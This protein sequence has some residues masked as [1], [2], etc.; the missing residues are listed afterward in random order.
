MKRDDVRAIAS[1]AL[2]PATFGELVSSWVVLTKARIGTFVVLA[3][4]TGGMLAGGGTQAFTAAL[5]AALYIGLVAA[6]SGVF[7]QVIERDVDARMPRTQNRPLVTGRIRVKDAIYVAALLAVVGTV[8]LAARFN[9]LTAL[10]S[11]GTLLA[12]T[13]VYTPLKRFT[14]LNTA[15][16]A[17]PGAM[18]PLLGYLAI[19]GAPGPW[20][21]VLFALL[22]VWQFPHFLAIAWLYRDDYKAGGMIMLPTLPHSEGVAGRQALLY[23]LAMLPVALLPFLRGEAG[24]LYAAGVLL[25]SVGYAVAAAFFA[26]RETVARARAVLFVSLAFLPLLFSLVLLDPAVSRAIAS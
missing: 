19:A 4:V 18:P 11:L 7:N 10:C 6:A 17:I 20:G 22:F 24:F 23:S 9:L 2:A 21:W 12:Y 26:H 5:E 25:L 14:S 1:D 15:V 8:G 13:L 16:G 3:A